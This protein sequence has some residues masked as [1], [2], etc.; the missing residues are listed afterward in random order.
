MSL[1]RV[2]ILI[3]RNES[4]VKDR[5]LTHNLDL[6]FSFLLFLFYFGGLSLFFPLS[7]SFFLKLLIFFRLFGYLR[8]KPIPYLICSLNIQFTFLNLSS[9]KLL[10]K[11]FFKS[12]DHNGYL[13]IFPFLCI[14]HYSGM[15]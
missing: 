7:L 10:N 8:L 15:D 5:Y 6:S 14:T 3:S 13:F 1:V 12:M 11:Q 9:L 2:L 4:H